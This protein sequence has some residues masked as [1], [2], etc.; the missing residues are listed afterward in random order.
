VIDLVIRTASPELLEETVNS[1]PGV[2]AVVVEGSFDGEVCT[3]RVHSS[4]DF[5]KYAIVQQGY[6]QIVSE[7]RAE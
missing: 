2:I 6:G 4:A 7:S 5:A 3:L 1:L